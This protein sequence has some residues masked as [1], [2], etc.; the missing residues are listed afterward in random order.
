MSATANRLAL[1]S[2]LAALTAPPS[3]SAWNSEWASG[4]LADLSGLAAAQSAWLDAPLAPRRVP[5]LPSRRSLAIAPRL[6][7]L[8]SAPDK[9]RLDL[10]SG[11][12]TASTL[13]LELH[14]GDRFTWR[15]R[16]DLDGDYQAVLSVDGESVAGMISAPH[17]I[18]EIVPAAQPGEAWLIELDS[19]QLPGCPGGVD[20]GELQHAHL[21]DS[22]VLPLDSGEQVDVLVM[23]SPAARTAAGGDSQI[24]AQAQAAVDSA[25]TAFANSQMRMRYRVVGIELMDGWVEGS[26]S[27]STELSNFR[28]NTTMQARRNA[29]AADMVSLL[30]AALPGACG[31]GYV[32]RSPGAG[33]AGSAVQITD[34]DCAVGNLSWAH[35]HGHN[36]GFEHDPANGGSPAS[37]S[38]PWS[39]GHYVE[40]Q[41]SQSYRTVMSYACPAGGCTRRP[42]FSNPR[43]SF[44]GFPT[45]IADE[46]DNARSG[47]AV[48]D[49]VANFRQSAQWPGFSNGFESP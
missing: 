24:R 22:Q 27:A 1:I 19:D 44:N 29:V 38:F 39:F 25:N 17:G 34:R 5:E 10:P 12:V 41:G 18:W 43:V 11:E 15:G 47:D 28:A 32:M 33:F 46:R 35:E 40:N 14:A 21:P 13:D 30:V 4:G 48:A 2:A 8:A 16:L 9:L 31:I 23:Y 42:Y 36:L 45:G 3:A 20:A 37:A 26:S 6:D 49:T 7:V